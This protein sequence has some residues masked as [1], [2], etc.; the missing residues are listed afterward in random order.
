MS[1]WIH[2]SD[3]LGTPALEKTL[4]HLTYAGHATVLVEMDGVRLLADPILRNHIGPL[5]RRPV[6]A[7]DWGRLDAVLISHFH[8][9]HLDIPSLRQLDPETLLVVPR[10]AI[11]ALRK[12]GFS[13]IVEVMPGEVVRINGL[14][15]QATPANHTS[16]RVFF[17]RGLP[18]VGFLVNG[19]YRIY[20]AGD[21]DLFPEMES[22]GH[23]LDIA[24]LPVWG[25]GPRLGPGHLNPLRAA[26][27]LTLLQPRVA[28]PIHWGSLHLL[29]TGWMKF[30][31]HPPHIFA[32]HAANLAPEVKVCILEPGQS[33]CPQTFAFFHDEQMRQA[34]DTH[35][36]VFEEVGD[37]AQHLPQGRQAYN[38][39]VVAGEDLRVVHHA[40][41]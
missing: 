37:A 7:P 2:H 38:D 11:G 14:S 17:G 31:S 41:G 33:L 35:R 13:R 9:D 6:P 39:I 40:H 12:R 4:P 27:S 8:Y 18:C 5:R 20:F 22:I 30:V 32:R 34:K 23:D 29:G 36:G 1:A 25:W 26:E 28:I 3:Y 10:G 24:L 19:S 15:I 16:S 21:T